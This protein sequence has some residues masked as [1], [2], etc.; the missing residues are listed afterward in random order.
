LRG[1]V[2]VLSFIVLLFSFL[3]FN[4]KFAE[5]SHEESDPHMK[6]MTEAAARGDADPVAALNYYLSYLWWTRQT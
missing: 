2:F 3:G 5:W 4:R 1:L 6:K